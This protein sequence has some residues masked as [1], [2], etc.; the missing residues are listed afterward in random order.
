MDSFPTIW[1]VVALMM[2]FASLGLLAWRKE[3]SFEAFF[4]IV[5]V[6][7]M[8]PPILIVALTIAPF[9]IFYHFISWLRSIYDA[10]EYSSKE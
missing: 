1:I 9:Y 7:F 8:W 5:L 10:I 6:A 3:E 4:I 2:T